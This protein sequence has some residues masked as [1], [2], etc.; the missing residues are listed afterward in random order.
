[1]TNFTAKLQIVG[2]RNY[3][4]GFET[5]KRSFVTAFSI[6]M[7]IPLIHL[8]HH[9]NIISWFYGSMISLNN[10]IN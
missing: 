1:M 4:D 10:F 9:G 5:P 2:M 6:C 7:T 3:Q 8:V